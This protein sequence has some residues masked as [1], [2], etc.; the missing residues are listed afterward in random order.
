MRILFLFAVKEYKICVLVFGTYFTFTAYFLNVVLVYQRIVVVLY[1]IISV[2]MTFY[3]L[4]SVFFSIFVNCLALSDTLSLFIASVTEVTE[5]QTLVDM[6]IYWVPQK[7][8]QIHTVIAYICI[9][10]V[11]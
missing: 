3:F 2:L 6:N 5:L 1:C 8:L 4:S 11:A 9:G 10:K 7:L